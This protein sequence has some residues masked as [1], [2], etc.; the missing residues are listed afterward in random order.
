MTG[1]LFRSKS[2]SGREIDESKALDS[3][4]GEVFRRT[5]GLARRGM[6]VLCKS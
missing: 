1:S 2:L 3:C 4:N 6:G 5:R